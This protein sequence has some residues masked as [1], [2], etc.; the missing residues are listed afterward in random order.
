MF[1]TTSTPTILPAMPRV[2]RLN[3]GFKIPNLSPRVEHSLAMNHCVNNT[4]LKDILSARSAVP[5]GRVCMAALP[6]SSDES[7]SSE[8]SSDEAANNQIDSVH[9]HSIDDT[10]LPNSDHEGSDVEDNST[11]D[12]LDSMDMNQ[13]MQVMQGDAD[14][15]ALAQIGHVN[16]KSQFFERLGLNL[17]EDCQTAPEQ[18]KCLVDQH[19]AELCWQ[20]YQQF[21]IDEIQRIQGINLLALGVVVSQALQHPTIEPAR[22]ATLS[23]IFNLVT[24]KL[25]AFKHIPIDEFTSEPTNDGATSSTTDELPVPINTLAEM[26]DLL[27][28]FEKVLDEFGLSLENNTMHFK[29]GLNV[30]SG[31]D[32][33]EQIRFKDVAGIDE[34]KQELMEVVDYLKNPQKFEKMGAKIPRG[35]LLEGGPG[36]GKTLL[37]KAVA[38]EAGV[39]FLSVSGSEFVEEYVGVGAK[40][41]RELFAQ[42]RNNEACIIFVD[43]IDAIGKKRSSRADGGSQEQEQTLNQLLVE[44]NGF[45]KDSG[46]IVIAATNRA[47]LLDSALTRPGRFDRSVNVPLPAVAGREAILKV[48]SKNKPLAQNVDLAIIAKMTSGFSGAELA[49]LVNESALNAIRNNREEITFVDF[50]EARDKYIM[51]VAMPHFKM[52]DKD[53]L[54][55]AYHEA[56]HALVAHAMDGGRDVFKVTIMPR[57]ES[58][59]STHY[60]PEDDGTSI[61][62]KKLMAMLS[63]LLA[64]RMAEGLFFGDDEITTGASNDLHRAT[65]IARRMVAEWGFSPIVGPNSVQY[66][67]E[68]SPVSGFTSQVVD[69]E[70]ARI[71][72]EANEQARDIIQS[73]RA[74]MTSMAELLVEKETIDATDVNNILGEHGK[75]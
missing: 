17:D 38:G 59:G 62:R 57:G 66:Q 2:S 72:N 3:L 40:R 64:G 1:I 52:S 15:I 60:I 46:V 8:S 31:D 73:K 18:D 50:E 47:D 28:T 70:V 67:G 10:D 45:A 43:E 39:P 56:G 21:Q 4:N 44:M 16:D 30:N 5:R 22:K 74:E 36:V 68:V 54:M 9:S 53:R 26:L 61:S 65:S 34:A 48:H 58:L 35:I 75:A 33:K 7:S 41:V 24:D 13:I 55:T 19:T 37:A 23:F 69:Q 20:A 63:S 51:G 42:A 32:Q 14:N 25:K 11:A 29:S 6:D 49:N 12:V 71:L 27:Q